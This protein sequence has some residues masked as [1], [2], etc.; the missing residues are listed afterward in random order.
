M[1][2]KIFYKLITYDYTKAFSINAKK[3]STGGSNN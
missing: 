2:Y 1:T 3:L